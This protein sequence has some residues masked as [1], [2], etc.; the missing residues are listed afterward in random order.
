MEIIGNMPQIEKNKIIF[1]PEDWLSGLDPQFDDGTF[2]IG[3]QLAQSRTMNPYRH[4]GML[5]PGFQPTDISNVSVVDSFLRKAIVNG[6]K[7][8]A[9]SA[10]V[11]AKLFEIAAL[12]GV[13]DFTTPTTFPKTISHH[14]AHSGSDIA[15]Y[16]VAG[17]LRLFYSFYDETDWDVGMYDLSTTFD[18]DYMSTV[19]ATPLASP[20]LTGGQGQPH[21]LVVGDD[22]LL[23]MGDRNFVHGYDGGT[24]NKFYP[25]V[26]TIPSSWVITSFA[27]YKQYLVV[28][29]YRSIA[30]SNQYA[31]ESKAYFWDYLSL[32]P[33]FSV[34]LNDNYVSEGFNYQG[35]VG[36]FTQGKPTDQFS[37]N[38]KITKL[39][40]FDPATNLF[41]PICAVDKNTPI[42]GGVDIR[43]HD[44]YWLSQG[45]VYMWDGRRKILNA[46]TE[47]SGSAGLSSST[48]MLA[49]LNRS[50]FLSTGT[51]N[52]GGLQTISSNYFSTPLIYSG[53]ARPLFTQDKVGRPTRVRVRFGKT[54]TGGRNI[55]VKLR[56]RLNDLNTIISSSNAL[57]VITSANMTQDFFIDADGIEFLP[58]ETLRAL[59]VWEAGDG[60]TDAPIVD[61]IEVDFETINK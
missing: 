38:S 16:S 19:P 23:Y 26:L 30:G 35:T 3:K 34:D 47:G 1:G 22:D 8:Y 24:A 11:P 50:Q 33:T 6:N 9:I 37:V 43:G 7:A 48:G 17:D 29:A 4:L 21:P 15:F 13:P 44:I 32:D 2:Q 31:G 56:D 27:K 40:L 58:F 5:T 45:T 46:L 25:A 20:Y 52:Q 53:L 55:I 12:D 28:F 36:C 10:G 59:V 18:D 54:S 41:Q 51:T 42:R 61:S 49:T 14:T 60:A 39:C 57:K